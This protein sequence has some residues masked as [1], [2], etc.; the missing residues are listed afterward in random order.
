MIA[1]TQLTEQDFEK[2]AREIQ[3]I[4]E[5]RTEDNLY[6]AIGYAL[7]DSGYAVATSN[8]FAILQPKMYNERVE[9]F[10]MQKSI[11]Y[12]A[13]IQPLKADEARKE[14]KRFWGRFKNTLKKVICSDEKVAKLINGE[15]TLKDYLITGIPLIITALGASALN[16]VVLAI[17]AA[18]LALIVKIGFAAYCEIENISAS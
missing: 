10:N 4:S 15:G 13:D 6:E 8:S 2:M 16:P 7:Y 5:T 17:V 18:V 14:G 11:D 12:V 1:L 3:E 9:K